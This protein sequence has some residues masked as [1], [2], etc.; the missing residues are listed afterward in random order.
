[1]KSVNLQ[2]SYTSEKFL[3]LFFWVL[4]LWSTLSCNQENPLRNYDTIDLL[5]M[6]G[7]IV[8]GEGNP[9]YN[10]HIYISD[11]KIV[12]VGKQSHK[13]SNIVKTIDAKGKYVAPGFIDL[14]AHGNPIKTPAFENF[15]AMGVT[16]IILGQDGSSPNGEMKIWMDRVDS[17][18]IGVNI[19]MFIGHG[20][21]RRRAG[22]GAKE[23]G[24]EEEMQKML[25]ELDRSL[26][27]CFGLSTGLEYSPGLFA[28]EEEMIALAKRVGDKGRMIMSHMRN[29]DDDMLENSIN[30]LLRQ[31]EF[32]KVH[33]AHIKS[34]YG[35]GKGRAEEIL[36]SLYAAR[37]KGIEITADIYPYTASYTGLSLLLPEWAKSTKQLKDAKKNRRNE[38]EDFI[39]NKVNKRNGPEATLLGS[40]PYA[41]KTLL[42]LEK[43]LK[44]PFEKIL[45]DDINPFA[46]SAA[47]F[48]MDDELQ[49]RLL[50]DPLV[51]ICSDGSPT[52]FHPRGH[53]TFA[54]VIEEFVENKKA[55]TLEEAVKK[56]T[57]YAA[58]ILGIKDRGVIEAGKMADLIV[59]NPQEIREKADYGNPFQLAEGFDIVIVNGKVARENGILSKT[60]NGKILNP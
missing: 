55:L 2:G 58:S 9:P 45:I 56:M 46:H 59:F 16:T 18:E 15:L 14:H 36:Q 52:G 37:E 33:I 30:E 7:Q 29:E 24:T 32:A 41:G 5:I 44:K 54:R 38:L 21:L 27:H 23:K 49:T 34:V 53:G 8:D 47:Y 57:S 50:V 1:M 11:E 28:Q 43:D 26:D 10:G 60:N 22:I 25:D 48:V 35:K 20:T 13:H 12:Y 51:S 19:G 17:M 40:A 42:D 4:T 39:R 6:N 3:F 31:G